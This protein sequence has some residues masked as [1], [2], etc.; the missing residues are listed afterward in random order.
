VRDF[1]KG[2]TRVCKILQFV[3]LQKWLS[4]C[5]GNRTNSAQKV[6]INHKATR[7]LDVHNQL[8]Q[9]LSWKTA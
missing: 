2:K 7:L 9:V 8:L 4:S 5:S 1:L 3:D 6:D